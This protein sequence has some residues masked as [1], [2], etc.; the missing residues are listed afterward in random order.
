[1]TN[2]EL[3]RLTGAVER[4]IERAS[5]QRAGVLSRCIPANV[6]DTRRLHHYLV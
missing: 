2:A 6:W 1:M 4:G 3:K 5:Q